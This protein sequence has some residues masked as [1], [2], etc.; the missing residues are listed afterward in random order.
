[1]TVKHQFFKNA[2]KSA[3][4]KAINLK[5]MKWFD[6]ELRAFASGYEIN[7][8][9]FKTFSLHTSEMLISL[10]PWYHIP[11]SVIQS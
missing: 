3:D 1:M 5:I 11:A 7:A 10:Y 9:K 6:V 4:T 2:E 8:K